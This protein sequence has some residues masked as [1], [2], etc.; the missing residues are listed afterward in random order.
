MDAV[1]NQ[2]RPGPPPGAGAAAVVAGFDAGA[3]AA[4]FAAGAG[5]EAAAGA[6]AVFAAGA[7]VVFAGLVV[8]AGAVVFAGVVLGAPH[9]VLSPLWPV[10]APSLT[11]PLK[12][13]PSLQSPVVPAGAL[14]GACATHSWAVRS[15][16]N[17]AIKLTSVFI[18]LSP[19]RRR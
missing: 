14:A 12:Y 6:G 16:A 4:G 15:A 9:Q 3:G 8:F 1:F 2:T 19:I 17:N 7:G 11:V 13:V 18:V 5:V 10:Q